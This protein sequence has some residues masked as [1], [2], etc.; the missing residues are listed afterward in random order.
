MTLWKTQNFPANKYSKTNHKLNKSKKKQKILE[1]SRKVKSFTLHNVAK[2][3]TQH[4]VPSTMSC[5]LDIYDKIISEHFSKHCYDIKNRPES[6]KLAKYFHKYY[7][8]ND[9]LHVIILE[10]DIKTASA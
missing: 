2:V 10:N 4:K 9:N 8:I 5:I 6:S 7:N 1:T 3:F